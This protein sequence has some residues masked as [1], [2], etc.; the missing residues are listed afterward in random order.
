MCQGLASHFLHGRAKTLAPP[1]RPSDIRRSNKRKMPVAAPA[2]MLRRHRAHGAFVN[3]RRRRVRMV[4][5]RQAINDGEPQLA[6]QP[7]QVPGGALRGQH[8]ADQLHI[9]PGRHRLRVEAY[10]PRIKNPRGMLR[11][12]FGRAE[13][14]FAVRMPAQFVHKY[15]MALDAH[16]GFALRFCAVFNFPGS[17]VMPLSVCGVSY[18]TERAMPTASSIEY[19]PCATFSPRTRA[20]C[21][22]TSNAL[23]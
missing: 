3:P 7:T 14:H 11:R 9:R 19:W 21:R 20:I 1:A 10:R 18:R 12:V 15:D 22:R 5:V 2:Q 4:L 6:T 16:A 17:D 23:A 8:R 13:A